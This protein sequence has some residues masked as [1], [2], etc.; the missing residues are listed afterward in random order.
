MMAQVERKQEE[1]KAGQRERAMQKRE[2]HRRDTGVFQLTLPVNVATLCLTNVMANAGGALR[3]GFTRDGGALALGM[4][5]GD[6]YATEYVRPNEDAW[7]ALSEIAGLWVEDGALRMA[8][9]AEKLGL[10]GWIRL[11]R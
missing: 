9:V 8:E 7:E 3:V 11:D 1:K 5:L 2:S 6:D 10:T 4:Y